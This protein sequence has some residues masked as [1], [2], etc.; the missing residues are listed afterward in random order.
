MATGLWIVPYKALRAFFMRFT[1]DVLYIDRKRRVRKAVKR[2]LP[3]ADVCVSARALGA[4]IARRDHR[5]H[6]YPE[7]RSTG[8]RGIPL[9]MNPD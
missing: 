4:G 8:N 6:Q 3:V 9:D 7:G 2:L 5:P 1:I